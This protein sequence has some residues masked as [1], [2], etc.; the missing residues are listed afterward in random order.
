MSAK[1]IEG[2]VAMLGLGILTTV[3]LFA[4]LGRVVRADE[5]S[6]LPAEFSIPASH[7]AFF[8]APAAGDEIFRCTED[9]GAYAWTL[10]GVDAKLL[11]SDGHVFAIQNDVATW[12]ATDGSRASGNASKSI[13]VRSTDS[14]PDTLYAITDRNAGG[15]LSQISDIIRDHVSGGLPPATACDASAVRRTVRVPFKADYIFFED[16]S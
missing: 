1:L 8:S 5:L 6:A 9:H 11:D 7:H 15:V 10:A 14:Q 2:R 13:T 12:V 16:A 3:I 4:L